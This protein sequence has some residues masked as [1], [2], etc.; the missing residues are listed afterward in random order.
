MA[1]RY[2]VTVKAYTTRYL[3]SVVVPDDMDVDEVI[4]IAESKLDAYIPSL[5]HHCAGN[6][7]LSDPDSVDVDLYETGVDDSRIGEVE[8]EA[9]N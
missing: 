3:G 8:E 1:K 6:M 9:E 7:D 2:G 5:C 4:E